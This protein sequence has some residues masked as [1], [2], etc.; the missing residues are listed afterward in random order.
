MRLVIYFLLFLLFLVI[1]VL[2]FAQ[3]SQA[4]TISFFVG[5]HAI[6]LAYIIVASIVIGFLLGI[7]SLTLP[8][9]KRKVQLKSIERQLQQRK[10]EIENLRTMPVRDDY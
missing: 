5:Q 10:Q 1:S 7:F 2:F 6:P 3:N 4:V 8:L 9:L